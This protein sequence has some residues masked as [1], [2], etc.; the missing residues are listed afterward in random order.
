MIK[1]P[2]KVVIIGPPA[3]GK[4]QLVRAIEQTID[5]I[6]TSMEPPTIA[7]YDGDDIHLPEGSSQA[8]IVIMTVQ[9]SA[10]QFDNPAELL[11]GYQARAGKI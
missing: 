10:E 9:C 4:T 5:H 3:S 7:S 1:G 2:L 6:N 8:D 11:R